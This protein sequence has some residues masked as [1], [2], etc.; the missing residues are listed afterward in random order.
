MNWRNIN[1]TLIDK[2]AI[3]NIISLYGK[4]ESELIEITKEAN[5]FRKNKTTM[6]PYRTVEMLYLFV[7]DKKPNSIVEFSPHDGWSTFW[8]LKALEKNKKG[9][10]H[11]FDLINNVAINLQPYIQNNYLKFYVGDVKANLS[12][13]LI[14]KSDFFYID[15]DHTAEMA[16]WYE[17]KILKQKKNKKTFFGVDDIFHRYPLSNTEAD[18]MVDYINKNEIKFISLDIH[19]FPENYDLLDKACSNIKYKYKDNEPFDPIDTRGNLTTI[20]FTL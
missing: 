8:I 20:F 5:E 13:D 2:D 18:F 12:D 17:N 11:S 1:K 7:R 6:L 19:E 15:S 10:L 14:E 16:I 9:V 4:Y 3:E